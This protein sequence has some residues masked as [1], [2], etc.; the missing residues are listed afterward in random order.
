MDA[1]KRSE[2]RVWTT[3]TYNRL[4]RYYDTFMRFFFP[5]GEKGRERIVEKLT[6]GSVLDVACGT[7]TLLE[8]ATKK[9][10]KCSGIDLSEGMLAQARRKVPKA[11]LRQASYYDIPYPEEAFNYVV[12]TNALSGGYIDASKVLAEMLRV[13]RSGGWVYIAEWPKAEKESFGERLLV[14]LAGLNDDAPKDY[15]KIFG[16]MGYEPEVEILSERY[17]VYGIRK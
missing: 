12:A 15:L 5:I 2:P 3:N 7:G 6:T 8:M 1:K 16:E 10:L 13:C 14:W 11:E 17:H 9:G 4:S